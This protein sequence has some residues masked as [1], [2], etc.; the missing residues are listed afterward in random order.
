MIDQQFWIEQQKKAD[1]DHLRLLAIFHFI[2]AGIIALGIGFLFIH[3]TFLSTM[4]EEGNFNF[5]HQQVLF[6]DS[7]M[8]IMNILVWFYIVA[9]ALLIIGAAANLLSGLFIRKRVFRVFSL[10]IAGINCLHMPIGTGLGAFTFIVLTR[11]TVRE[12]YAK[13]PVQSAATDQET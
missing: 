7:P 6:Q 3:Y 8:D 12:L 1:A 10:V 9:G 13:T 5:R 4:M 11:N 2:H